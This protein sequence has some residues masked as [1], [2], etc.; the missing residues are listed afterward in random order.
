MDL[1]VTSELQSALNLLKATALDA[2]I[3][4]D[5][6]GIVTD[7]N[8]RAT[9][10]LGF[11][12]EEAVGQRLA[13]L[14]IPHRHRDAH[15]AGLAKFLATGEGKLLG[16]R[17]EVPALRKGG[18]EFPAELTISPVSSGA[19]WVFVGSLRDLSEQKRAERFREQQA[20]KAEVLYRIVTFAAE[21]RAFTEALALCL[22]CVHRLTGWPVGH[23]YLP[24][25]E[26]PT[27]LMPS[28]IWHVAD[29]VKFAPLQ[30]ATRGVYLSPGDG[31]PGRVWQSGDIVWIPDISADPGMRRREAALTAGLRSAVGLPI[32]S[33]SRIIAILEFF[34]DAPTAEDADLVLTLRA[35]AYQC[36]RVFERHETEQ[37]LRSLY[38][39]AQAELQERRK[40]EDQLHLLLGEL[41]HRV[42]NMLAVVTGI[43]AQTAR[44]SRSIAAFTAKFM[45]RLTSLGRAHTLLTARN[46]QPTPLKRLVEE[47]LAPY[48]EPQDGHLTIAGPRVELLPKS[49]L[50][51]S[52]ILHE[53]V[54]NAT[55][56]GALSVPNGKLAVEWDL[57]PGNPEQ[58]RLSWRESGLAHLAKPRRT[59]FGTRM[60]DASVRHELGGK[61]QVTYRPVGIAY[62]IDFPVNQ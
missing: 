44:N 19:E 14:I 16:R 40:A 2:V 56:F 29:P 25:D 51:I 55:K 37:S 32:L 24:T 38:Q 23:V 62:E 53:L 26:E 15:H 47:L 54:T 22:D 13:G 57:V 34:T 60:I 59:G 21:S 35:F 41:N 5:A 39:Q 8:D 30:D 50:A 7:W 12:E 49:A 45:S 28:E 9:A 46:W 18:Q 27:I 3:V 20:L 4:M 6:R 42:K 52:M 48:A 17:I 61:V 31:L 36:G 33:G 58:V 11:T 1:H 10:I 43:A